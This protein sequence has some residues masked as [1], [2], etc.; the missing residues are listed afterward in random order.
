MNPVKPG[1][2]GS[3]PGEGWFFSFLE[4]LQVKRA[5]RGRK[6]ALK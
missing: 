5:A 1:A 6:A 4:A 3:C 2:S